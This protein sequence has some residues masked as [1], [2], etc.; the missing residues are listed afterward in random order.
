MSLKCLEISQVGSSVAWRKAQG[1][2]ISIR[3]IKRSEILRAGVGRLALE[4]QESLV[5]VSRK[6][7]RLSGG[8]ILQVSGA[9]PGAQEAREGYESG[10]R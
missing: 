7:Q 10:P 1:T 3:S 8:G 9:G 5:R 6:S 4:V 2:S